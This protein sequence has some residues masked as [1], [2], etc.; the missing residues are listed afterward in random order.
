MPTI[1]MN[2]LGAPAPRKCSKSVEGLER[3]KK[4]LEVGGE[5]FCGW[6]VLFCCFMFCCPERELRLSVG[7][8]GY[9]LM[10]FGEPAKEK[11][12]WPFLEEP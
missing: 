10:L 12:P 11:V 4:L 7:H 8:N 6:A 1:R 2:G 5:A 3:A 9:F